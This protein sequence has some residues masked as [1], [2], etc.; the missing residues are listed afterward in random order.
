MAPPGSRPLPPPPADR[1][2]LAGTRLGDGVV[3]WCVRLQLPGT[4]EPPSSTTEVCLSWCSRR[5]AIR[6]RIKAIITDNSLV[7]ADGVFHYS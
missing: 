4:T 6:E 7:D 3:Q 5:R 1:D 2:R